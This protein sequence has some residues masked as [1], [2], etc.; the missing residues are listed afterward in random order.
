M[1]RRRKPINFDLIKAENQAECLRVLED[2]TRTRPYGASQQLKDKD[3][4]KNSYSYSKR[5]WNS[6]FLRSAYVGDETGQWNSDTTN[7]FGYTDEQLYHV[8]VMLGCSGESASDWTIRSGL[9]NVVGW[10]GKKNT[11]RSQKIVPRLQKAYK[12]WIENPLV[13]EKVIEVN[14]G[15]NHRGKSYEQRDWSYRPS[16]FIRANADSDAKQVFQTLFGHVW[17]EVEGARHGGT[18]QAEF[19]KMGDESATVSGNT[20]SINYLKK[21]LAKMQKEQERAAAI[22]E[23]LQAGIESLEMFNISQFA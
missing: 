1:A 4:I 20:E 8:A 13:T 11:M 16:V 5:D 7:W 9:R 18:L 22:M 2:L 14:I 21:H 23:E 15:M 10:Y 3:Y 17:P 6:F 19:V 12:R